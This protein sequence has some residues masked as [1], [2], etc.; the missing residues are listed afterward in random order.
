MSLCVW[1]TCEKLWHMTLTFRFVDQVVDWFCFVYLA[2]AASCLEFCADAQR[3]FVGLGNGTIKVR[4]LEPVYSS[5]NMFALL[6]W[7]SS[8][9][10][11]TFSADLK[12]IECFKC[13]F[14]ICEFMEKSLFY[15]RF[16]MCEVSSFNNNNKQ[17]IGAASPRLPTDTVSLMQCAFDSNSILGT[18][19]LALPVSVFI[20]L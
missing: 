9:L 11:S 3:L 14:V 10:K 17:V 6:M 18:T 4:E 20:G 15:N 5:L 12:F 13:L 8:N 1:F 7:R 2:A 19:Q 16:H